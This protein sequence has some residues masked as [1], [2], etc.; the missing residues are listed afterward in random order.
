MEAGGSPEG[1]LRVNLVLIKW[2]DSME[3]TGW[4]SLA[5]CSKDKVTI[6]K[7]VGWLL[8]DG[9]E[10]KTLVPHWLEGEGQ[11]CGVLE[12]PTTA[13]LSIQH[14]TEEHH[15][16]AIDDHFALLDGPQVTASE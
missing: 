10:V 3:Y 12:I 6:C 14:F 4:Q 2:V 7:S 13:I 9:E 5:D 11:G 1:R 8:S 16:N 15:M